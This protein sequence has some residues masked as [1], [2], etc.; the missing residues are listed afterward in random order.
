MTP[1]AHTFLYTFLVVALLSMTGVAAFLYGKLQTPASVN[2]NGQVSLNNNLPPLNGNT[3][4]NSGQPQNPLTDHDTWI[5]FSDDPTDFEEGTLVVEGASVPEV[6]VCDPEVGVSWCEPN[7]IFIYYVDAT[8]LTSPGTEQLGLKRSTDG[9]Q[10]WSEVEHVVIEGKPDRRVAVDP[11]VAWLP[12]GRL[13]LY[14][15]GSENLLGDPAAVEGDH[16]MYSA[17]S[18][19][20][21]NFTQE[22]GQRLAREKITDPE[23]VEWNGKW[24]MLYSEG[25]NSGLAVSED[26][27][28]FED[29]GLIDPSFGGVP[30]L[31]AT[32]EGLRGYGCQKGIMTA[33]STDGIIF[34][35]ATSVL[36]VTTGALC[37]PAVYEYEEGYVMVYKTAPLLNQKPVEDGQ[38]PTIKEFTPDTNSLVR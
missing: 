38:Q 10:T 3:N 6:I 30:G 20:G 4:V 15:F 36:S 35:T 33:L 32:D 12:D 23:V 27:L 37:D 2:V 19:D 21:L 18:T 8:T 31:L 5:T 11:S 1:K 25:P 7:E 34:S 26:G 17:V 28:E 13:R 9:G 14:Y 24:Y 29:Q 22:D 16:Y